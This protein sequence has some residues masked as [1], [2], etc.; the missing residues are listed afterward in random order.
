MSKR[1]TV[2]FS[3]P[4]QVKRV[5]HPTTAIY[6]NNKILKRVWGRRY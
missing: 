3:H 4:L 5:D 1:N 2:A 6:K